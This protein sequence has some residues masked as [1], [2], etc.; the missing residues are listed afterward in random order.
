VAVF[1]ELNALDKLEGFASFY[2]ADFYGLERN[3]SSINLFKED[4]VV[5]EK[6]TVGDESIIPLYAGRKISWRL[7]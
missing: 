5:P 1:D 2:G 6:I 7:A 3:K 4:W